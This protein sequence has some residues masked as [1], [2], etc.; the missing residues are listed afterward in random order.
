[1]FLVLKK[2]W[3][4]LCCWSEQLFCINQGWANAL[5]PSIQAETEELALKVE[6]LTAENDAIKSEIEQ[7]TD[8][9]EKLRLENATLM[10]N[11]YA[12]TKFLVASE[13][14]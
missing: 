12:I 10:V 6:S 9:S 13:I 3:L 7:L 2:A 4:L 8:N 14:N 5:Q 11:P 1:M